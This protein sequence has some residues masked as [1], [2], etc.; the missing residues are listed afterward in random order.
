MK[1]KVK[2]ELFKAHCRSHTCTQCGKKLRTKMGKGE[3]IFVA[4]V[5]G[6]YSLF[7]GFLTFIDN[8]NSDTPDCYVKEMWSSNSQQEFW[9]NKDVDCPKSI[10]EKY[11]D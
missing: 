6:F 8:R 4:C 1:N 11:A 10:V 5:I 2:T 3:Y 9:V 7:I